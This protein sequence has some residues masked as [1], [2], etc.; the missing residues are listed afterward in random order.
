[1]FNQW[2]RRLIALVSS[3]WTSSFSL[4]AQRKRNQK[5]RHPGHPPFGYPA[6]LRKLTA[7]AELTYFDT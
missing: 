5:K 3:S 4:F 2:A 1:M 6:L 7:A